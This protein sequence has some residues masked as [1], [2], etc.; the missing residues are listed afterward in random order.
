MVRQTLRFH[1]HGHCQCTNLC[2]MLLLRL[3]YGEI[4]VGVIQLVASDV[5]RDKD[6]LLIR[7]Q[8]FEAKTLKSSF[9][10]VN[11]PSLSAPHLCVQ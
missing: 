3:I 10:F 8:R 7:L 9:C 5:V 6:E 11:P 1:K 4:S 2:S